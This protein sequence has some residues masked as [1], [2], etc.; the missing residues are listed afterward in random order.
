M[1]SN[2]YKILSGIVIAITVTIFFGCESNFKNV[3]NINTKEFVPI[4]EAD[5]VNLKYTDSG[6]IKAI[7]VSKKMFDYSNVSFPFT[8]FPLGVDVTLY[9]EKGKNSFIRSDYAI[10]YSKSDIIDLRGN[11]KITSDDGKMLETEQL[12]YDQKN[13]WFF[14]ESDYKFT[15]VKAESYGTGVDF[16]KDFK[17]IKTRNFRAQIDQTKDK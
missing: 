3:Q 5:S 7:L 1:K 4:G 2:I 15:D 11:V 16:S 10:T 17:V 12:Y 6:K 8:E 9:D 14:T 13:E